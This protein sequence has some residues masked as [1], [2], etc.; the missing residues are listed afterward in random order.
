MSISLLDRRTIDG[1]NSS[2]NSLLVD[3]FSWCRMLAGNADDVAAII[4]SFKECCI[5]DT[6]AFIVVGVINTE[7]FINRIISEPVIAERINRRF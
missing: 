3:E 5:A 7:N 2:V 1:C 6:L 4:V